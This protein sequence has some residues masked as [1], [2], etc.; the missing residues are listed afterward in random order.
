MPFHKL[1]PHF[2]S[3]CLDGMSVEAS[4]VTF[5]ARVT[6]RYARCPLCQGRSNRVHSRYWRRVADLPISGHTV[7]L[8]L[9]IRRFRCLTPSC[10]RR[11]FAERV[12]AL[13]AP[14]ARRSHGLR[15]A[16]EEIAFTAG[17]EGGS[18]L[19]HQ[20]GMPTSPDTLLRLIRAAPC[21]DAGQPTVI[22]V[23]DWGA[24]R[25]RAA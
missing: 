12:P 15:Q 19:A 11:L 17:G 13:V 3:L 1:F 16:L 2:R 4:T 24:T 5:S 25:S 7:V 23:D 6:R 22:G 20:L 9:Q 10:P 14:H 18:R 8:L 21:P